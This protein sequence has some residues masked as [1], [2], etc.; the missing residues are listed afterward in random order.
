M[1]EFRCR[2]CGGKKWRRRGMRIKG[3]AM[4][5]AGKRMKKRG[6]AESIER[7]TRKVVCIKCGHAQKK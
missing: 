1:K 3:K 2:K 7:H 5:S 6:G 4:E